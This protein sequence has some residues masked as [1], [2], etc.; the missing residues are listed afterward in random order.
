MRVEFRHPEYAKPIVTSCVQEIREYAERMPILDQ[1]ATDAGH[2]CEVVPSSE[3][4][5][6]GETLRG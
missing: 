1:A 5:F 4:Q 2:T 3:E 6:P